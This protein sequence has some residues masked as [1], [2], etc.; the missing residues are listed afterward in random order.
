MAHNLVEVT[1]SATEAFI[2]LLQVNGREWT[3][4]HEATE[5]PGGCV[6]FKFLKIYGSHLRNTTM[7]PEQEDE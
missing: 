1:Q 6:Y 3:R 4:E 2:C 5:R 7:S